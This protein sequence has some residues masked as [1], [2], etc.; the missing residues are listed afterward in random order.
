VRLTADQVGP[1]VRA[2]GAAVYAAAPSDDFVPMRAALAHLRALDPDLSGAQLAPAD[3]NDETGMPAL[4]WMTR[5]WAEQ[6]VARETPALSSGPLGDAALSQRLAQRA[7]LFT[8]L[9]ESP[10]LPAQDVRAQVK[11]LAGATSACVWFDHLD[12]GGR[13]ARVRVDLVG[14]P[15]QRDLGLC[16]VSSSGRITCAHGLLDLLARTANLPL[17]LLRMAL[18]DVALARV[19][20]VSRGAIGPF[21]MPGVGLP[22]G[23]P[24]GIARSL[25]LNLV[26]EVAGDGVSH[27]GVADP[28]D[29]AP[30]AGLPHGVDAFRERRFAVSRGAESAVRAWVATTGARVVVTPYG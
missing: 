24:P 25:C 23:V 27:A 16:A 8:H 10:L 13:W 9:R 11:R 4:S 20:R 15:E 6:V 1:Y 2:L 12:P 28:V 21:W 5:A 17:G 29:A 3:V 14:A 19:S 26:H 22:E 30:V 7:A 18:S